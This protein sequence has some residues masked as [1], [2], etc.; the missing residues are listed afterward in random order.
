MPAPPSGQAGAIP[1][2]VLRRAA[3]LERAAAGR[4]A[5]VGVLAQIPPGV[6]DQRPQFLVVA[7]PGGT[8]AVV[9]TD[10][11]LDVDQQMQL[12]AEPFVD[13]GDHAVGVGIFLPPPGRRGQAVGIPPGFVSRGQRAT[14]PG[15]VTP[16]VPH[17]RRQRPDHPI[18]ELMQ[19]RQ[20]RLCAYRLHEAGH[21]PAFGDLKF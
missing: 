7:A 11:V 9:Q 16:Q 6:F 10:L 14:V 1:S 17:G 4:I 20:V 12:V 8:D 19:Q 15:G 5:V 18:E 13:P 2:L 3:V 21:V